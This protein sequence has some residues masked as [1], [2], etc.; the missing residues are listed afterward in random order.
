MVHLFINAIVEIKR[1]LQKRSEY[2]KT[3]NDLSR[4]TDKELND[5]GLHRGLIRSVA[6]GHYSNP[7]I[8]GWV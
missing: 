2:K 1:K 6:L 8:K 5:I 4:L 3:V 7:N